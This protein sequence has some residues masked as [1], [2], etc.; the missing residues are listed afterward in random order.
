[1]R[2]WMW[3]DGKLR[4]C[5]LSLAWPKGVNEMGQVSLGAAPR[6][7]KA[8]T[9]D[10]TQASPPPGVQSIDF[11]SI[12][13]DQHFPAI[14]AAASSHALDDLCCILK[15]SRGPVWSAAQDE[16]S[17]IYAR[18]S[19]REHSQSRQRAPCALGSFV[20]LTAACLSLVPFPSHSHARQGQHSTSSRPRSSCK[21]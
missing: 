17:K 10:P 11:C 2:G 14:T 4:R 6:S 16:Q 8:A 21:Q 20:A 9:I 1:M 15:A 3:L 13:L 7:L 18:A 19:S 5:P 12:Q